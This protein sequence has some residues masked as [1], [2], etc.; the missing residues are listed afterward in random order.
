[1]LPRGETSH[2]VVV[3]VARPDKVTANRD[4]LTQVLDL[5]VAHDGWSYDEATRALFL[6]TVHQR[7]RVRIVVRKARE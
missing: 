1:M 4:G 7:E 5:E 6:K 3:P 2:C